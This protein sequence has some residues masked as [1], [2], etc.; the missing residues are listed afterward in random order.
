MSEKKIIGKE[1][2]HSLNNKTGISEMILRITVEENN[3]LNRYA[4]E[5]NTSKQ[6]LIYNGI[7]KDILSKIDEYINDI[8]ALK[9]RMVGYS[10]LSQ[11]DST[12]IILRLPLEDRI[13]INTFIQYFGGARRQGVLYELFVKDFIRNL[14]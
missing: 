2:C 13:K 8:D 7:I 4:K 5:H 12:T 6:N 9:D 14:G 3:I 1:Y 11:E 10:P